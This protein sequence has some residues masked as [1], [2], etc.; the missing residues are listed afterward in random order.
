MAKRKDYD[1]LSDKIAMNEVW[2]VA[3]QEAQWYMGSKSYKVMTIFLALA[4]IVVSWCMF[5]CSESPDQIP[6]T[7]FSYE[8]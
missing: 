4:M 2:V 5:L 7:I 3:K 1:R 6:P 8:M